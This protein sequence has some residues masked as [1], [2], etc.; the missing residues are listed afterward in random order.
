MNITYHARIWKW[1][2]HIEKTDSVLIMTCHKTQ[3][4]VWSQYLMPEWCQGAIISALW[5][6]INTVQCSCNVVSFI[7]NAHNSHPI[8]CWWGRHMGCLLWV[9]AL[10]N[11]QPQSLH[12]H[13]LLLGAITAFNC[14]NTSKGRIETV[15]K[16]MEN[17]VLLQQVIF[18]YLCLLMAV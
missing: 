12:Y 1:V 8:T 13:V 14:S 15:G 11:L 2:D 18:L 4:D 9:Q 3:F 6:G 10:I 5:R 7:Q 16:Y 17:S